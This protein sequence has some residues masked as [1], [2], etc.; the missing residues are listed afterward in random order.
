MTAL[1]E[2]NCQIVDKFSIL[3]SILGDITPYKECQGQADGK[4]ATSSS[5]NK[6]KT[7]EY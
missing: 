3:F 6:Y 5:A 2:A 7:I 1:S 4:V